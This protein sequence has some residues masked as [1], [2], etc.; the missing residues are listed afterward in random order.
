[1]VDVEER[2][3]SES[4]EYLNDQTLPS[5][6]TQDMWLAA[7]QKFNLP[8]GYSFSRGKSHRPS[9]RH[10]PGRPLPYPLYEERTAAQGSRR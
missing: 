9:A 1:M 5:K 2:E 10:V 3:S 8:Q 4:H 7:S 6:A